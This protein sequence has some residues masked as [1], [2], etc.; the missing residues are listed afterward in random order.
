M[1]EERKEL[2]KWGEERAGNFLKKEKGFE[3]LER[4]YRCPLGEIDIIARDRDVLV[5]VEVKTKESGDY[6]PPQVS[7]TRAKQCQ[8]VR[9]ARWYLKA[10]RM[11]NRRCRFDVLAVTPAPGP[12]PETIEYFPAAFR[13]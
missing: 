8:V 5:F 11:L 7:V 9:V 10:N 12:G 6:L 13:A 3:I 4:N 2:G 1:T